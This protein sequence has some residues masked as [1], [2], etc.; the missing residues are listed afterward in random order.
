MPGFRQTIRRG[1]SLVEF[2]VISLVTYM[3]LAAILTFG[4]LLFVAQGAQQAVD[5]LAREISRTPLPAESTLE[6]ALEDNEVKRIYDEHY[7]VID[8]DNLQGLSLQDFIARLP[9]VNQQLVPLMVYDEIDGGVRVLR[10]PGAVYEDNDMTNDPADPPP[11]GYL[12]AIPLVTSRGGDGTE[13]IRW[14][15]VVEE[16]EPSDNT[17]PAADPFQLSSQQQGVVALRINYPF[18]SAS[19]SSFRPNPAGT[20]EPNMGN[21]NVANDGGVTV[22]NPG[23]VPGAFTPSDFQFGPNTGQYG[24]GSQAAFGSAALPGPVRPYRKV[25]SAQAIYRREIFTN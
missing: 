19:M 8:L 6:D 15:P 11:S 9:M 4:H 16:I 22:E 1:Q 17:D 25:V 2:A 23:D 24:L 13:T 20:Y 5:S 18:Q 10:Y 12:V 7:L 14:V 21:P 3:L